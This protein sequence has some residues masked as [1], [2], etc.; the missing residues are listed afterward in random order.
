MENTSQKRTRIGLLGC[1]SVAK[2][3]AAHQNAFM[4]AAVYDSDKELCRLFSE[5]YSVSPCSGVHELLASGAEIIVEDA[6]AET[7]SA[8]VP[9]ILRAGIDI[10]LTSTAS[11][12][13][14][15]FREMLASEARASGA[16][17]HIPSGAVFGLDN[18][19]ICQTTPITSLHLKMTAPPESYGI[20]NSISPFIFSGS[21]A[22]CARIYP[23][24][25]RSAAAVSLIAGREASVEL[26]ADPAVRQITSELSLSGKFGD[27]F[28]RTT[29][30]IS[31][32]NPAENPLLAL[33]VL[34]ILENMHNPFV[35]GAYNRTPEKNE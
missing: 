21:A 18:I 30:R 1:G 28:I 35:V 15:A 13:D 33:S 19:R 20:A 2:M 31:M 34:A 4:I 9:E 6:S 32:K 16:K 24:N 29:S 7:V 23:E 3:L 25:S 11:L 5:E 26:W 27:V 14:S 10:I 12:A 22:D 17:I 8:H